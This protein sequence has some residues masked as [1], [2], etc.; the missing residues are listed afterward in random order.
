MKIGFY[1]VDINYINYLKEIEI[2]KRGF[3]T[4]PNVEYTSRNKFLYGAVMEIDGINYY[5]PV[6]SYTKKQ[7]DNIQIKVF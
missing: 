2:E 6:S 7:K 3:T 1:Y 5:V 4:V